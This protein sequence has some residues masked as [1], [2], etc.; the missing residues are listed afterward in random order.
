MVEVL[1]AGLVG[2][3][4]AD[5]ASSFLDAEGDPPGTGQ[6]IIAIDA[7]ALSPDAPERFA[8]LAGAIEGQ[9]GA[10]LPGARRL[11][12]RQ[13]AAEAGLDLPDALVAEIRAL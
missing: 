1:A 11:G 10:R 5:E 4:F 3:R 13:R 9:D 12:L 6:L 7:A 2:A 8:A